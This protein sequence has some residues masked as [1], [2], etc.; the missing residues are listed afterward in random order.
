[1]L[2]NLS[3]A[4]RLRISAV[5]PLIILL[6]V[7]GYA[8]TGLR[9]GSEALQLVHKDAVTTRS[10]G[11]IVTDMYRI[12]MELSNAVIA[13]EPPEMQSLVKSADSRMTEI[14]RSWNQYLDSGLLPEQKQAADTAAK[15]LDRLLD[16]TFQP[17]LVALRKS[18]R[19]A[20]K[21]IIMHDDS[22]T[23]STKVRDQL[24]K[25]QQTH[26]KAG[27]AEYAAMADRAMLLT[28][29][30]IATCVA[31]A[32]I[33]MWF[34]WLTSRAITRPVNDMR[35]AL[36]EAHRSNDLTQRVAVNGR[37]EVADMGHAFNALM[38]S[39]QSTLNRVMTDAQE[40]STAAT[41]MAAASNQM[42]ETSRAQS[43]SAAST[44]AAVEEVTVSINQVADNTRETRSVSEQACEL[45]TAGEKSARAAAEQM[46]GTSHSV[47]HSMRLIEQLSQRSN[48]ISGIVKVIRDIAEQTNLLALNAAIEAARAGEQGRGFAVVADEVRKLAERTSSST[49]EISAMIESIQGEVG[50]AVDNLKSNN[51]QV[52]QGKSL[53][54]EV[55]A[56]LARINEGAR[57]TMERINDISS[58]AAEQ[59]TASNDIARNVEKIAQMTEETSAAITQASTTAQQLEALAS[60][61]HA[62][63]TQFKTV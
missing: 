57:I 47:G 40:V 56:T 59:G 45:S 38:Q 1:M 63:V 49:S 13:D 26:S 15:D 17:A 11:G 28:Y 62:E 25:L 36:L 53:A 31:A 12:R 48:E 18:D 35:S 14:M 16:S 39:L 52:A 37:N 41:Q 32:A 33:L 54:E 43:E 50:R 21:T 30:L 9:S 23:L 2:K 46:L 22:R 4:A 51:E 60:K 5:L 29:V 19:E 42:T 55:A 44:A 24:E 58:A 7:S 61:L 8:W 6:A 10:I 34:S 3:I 20:A 27:D